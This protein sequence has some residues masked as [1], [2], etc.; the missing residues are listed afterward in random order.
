MLTYAR[1]FG[2]VLIATSRRRRL[3][4]LLLWIPRTGL[5]FSP[6]PPLFRLQPRLCRMAAS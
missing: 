5:C 1:T 2:D 6:P 3:F 4:K